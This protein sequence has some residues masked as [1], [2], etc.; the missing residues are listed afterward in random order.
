MGMSAAEYVRRIV[1]AALTVMSVM[2]QEGN[3]CRDGS[4]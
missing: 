2:S 3:V 4:E 1:V